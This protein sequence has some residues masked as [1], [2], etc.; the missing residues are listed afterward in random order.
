MAIHVDH[1]DSLIMLCESCLDAAI[2]SRGGVGGAGE[3]RPN[4]IQPG[5]IGIPIDLG[6][7][8]GAADI[9]DG[10]HIR[11]P[12][13]SRGSESLNIPAHKTGG[14]VRTAKNANFIEPVRKK[15]RDAGVPV[16]EAGRGDIREATLALGADPNQVVLEITLQ[17][18]GLWCWA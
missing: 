8:I 2:K 18:G 12:L 3:S 1:I 11:R 13:D 14:R 4:G 5:G 6:G 17:Q 10:D 16:L 9:A 7:V 15:A